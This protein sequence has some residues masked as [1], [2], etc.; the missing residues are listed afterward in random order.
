M[1]VGTGK[2]W[3]PASLTLKCRAAA[4]RSLSGA[5][6]KSHEKSEAVSGGK[7]TSSDA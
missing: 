2:A 6:L 4:E 7:K 1:L 3:G 5:S